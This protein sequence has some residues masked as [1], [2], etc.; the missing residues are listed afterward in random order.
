MPER[1]DSEVAAGLFDLAIEL[2]RKREYTKA[3]SVLN[4]LIASYPEMATLYVQR[5]SLLLAAKQMEG[6]L[7]DFD[8]ALALDPLNV[9]GHFGSGGA[10]QAQGNLRDAIDSYSR[11]LELQPN[12]A[13]AL[14]NRA[15]ALRQLGRID[16]AIQSYDAAI[17]LMPD[18]PD[19]RF[20]KGMCL[21]LLGSFQQG[22]PLYEWRKAAIRPVGPPAQSGSPW[23][24]EP[25]D[26][27]VLLIQAEQGLGDTIQF[28]RF[29]AMAH[30]L[31]AKVVLQVQDRL[32]RLLETLPFPAGILGETALPPKC[33]YHAMLLSMPLHFRDT[34]PAAV[35][36]LSAEPP[37]ADY[38]NN[39]LGSRGFKIG[40]S[41]QGE[42]SWKGEDKPEDRTRS[43]PLRLFQR[44]SKIPDVRLI[45]LQKGDG[46]EQLAAL[47][48]GMAVETLG[49]EFD[50][51]LQSFLDTAAVMQSLDL[52]ISADTA[53]AHLAGA[54]GRPFWVALKHVP[55]WRWLLGREDSP[56][57]PSCRLFRQ[58]KPDDWDDVFSRMEVEIRR[59]LTSIKVCR[60]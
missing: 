55:D 22:W 10:L 19:F 6:A 48:E 30:S 8:R 25:L 37:R 50:A 45:S 21:L 20:G 29:G 17:D 35:P 28:C 13:F 51:G 7:T 38:W 14:N 39:R 27:K 24:G 36:Y 15:L 44:I 58:T 42:K 46:I 4:E 40:I 32:T 16:E 43:F 26:G 59:Q 23:Q 2:H 18:C 5:G 56:W 49:E 57:Y 52:V 47:P 60:R 1:I 33:D 12:H 3:L 54:L 11:A 9:E 34:I 31:G 41:W 53:I